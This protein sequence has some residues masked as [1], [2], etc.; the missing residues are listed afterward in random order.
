MESSLYR[1][2]LPQRRFY[3]LER[4]FAYQVVTAFLDMDRLP[5][6]PRISPYGSYNKWNWITY[7][8]RDRF[9]QPQKPLRELLR[10]N[11]KRK[12][13][14]PA[15]LTRQAAGIVSEGELAP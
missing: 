1:G 10:E 2:K 7:D 8:E 15:N 4:Q 6:L 5:E 14:R 11:T 12:G 3:S 9:G 13:V